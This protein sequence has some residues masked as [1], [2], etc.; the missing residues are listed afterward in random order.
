MPAMQTPM[1]WLVARLVLV[2]QRHLARIG[3]H[4]AWFAR[5]VVQHAWVV[6][7]EVRC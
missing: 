4:H 2:P 3:E 6:H 1:Q 7:V 5:R